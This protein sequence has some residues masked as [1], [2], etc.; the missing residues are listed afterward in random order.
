MLADLRR[1]FPP[2]LRRYAGIL[3][4]LSFDHYLSRHWLQFS[5]L[6]LTEFIP[7]VYTSLESHRDYLSGNAGRMLGRMQQYDLL[8]RY[9]NWETIPASAARIGERFR[10]G[11]PFTDAREQLEPVRAILQETFL[12]FYPDLL[13]FTATAKQRLN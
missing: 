12:D 10:R 3:I 2:Q 13:A 7:R 4:D 5:D 6:P 9:G 1:H 8:G 11:N